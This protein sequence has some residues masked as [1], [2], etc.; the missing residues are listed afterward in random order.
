MELSFPLLD[1]EI[2]S[3]VMFL[4]VFVQKLRAGQTIKSVRSE[5]VAEPR[6]SKSGNDRL[7]LPWQFTG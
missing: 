3:L 1:A 6:L 5:D 7:A 4:R 2:D